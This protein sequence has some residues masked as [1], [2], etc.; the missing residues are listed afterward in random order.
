MKFLIENSVIF[1]VTLLVITQLIVP[2]FVSKLPMWWLFKKSVPNTEEKQPPIDL[3]SL[4]H[5]V[6]TSVEKYNETKNK[7]A[8][9]KKKVTKME[10][11]IK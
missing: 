7:V 6:E 9:V 5:E 2:A 8:E 4:K 11:K 10:E 3:E 1:L